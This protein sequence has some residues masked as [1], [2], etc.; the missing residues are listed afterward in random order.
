MEYH[1]YKSAKF[2]KTPNKF[3]PTKKQHYIHYVGLKC[4]K[5][6]RIEFDYEKLFLKLNDVEAKSKI[7]TEYKQ[8]LNLQN[9]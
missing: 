7:N 3:Y 6:Y 1:N 8:R 5:I 9:A 2:F 4:V